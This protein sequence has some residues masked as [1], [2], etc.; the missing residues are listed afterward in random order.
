VASHFDDLVER[1]HGAL[2]DA[3]VG[4]L[5][6]YRNGNER[7]ATLALVEACVADPGLVT[8]A[9]RRGAIVVSRRSDE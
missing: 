5:D 3:S 2:E 9:R 1:H 6:A 8:G 4:L 7:S